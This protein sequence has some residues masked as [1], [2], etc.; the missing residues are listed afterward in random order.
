MEAGDRAGRL[1]VLE[2]PYCT[3]LFVMVRTLP[4]KASAPGAELDRLSGDHGL[5]RILDVAACRFAG[6]AC[7]TQSRAEWVLESVGVSQQQLAGTRPSRWRQLEQRRLENEGRMSVRAGRSLSEY[8]VVQIEKRQDFTANGLPASH[9]VQL[10]VGRP[11]QE[12]TNRPANGPGLYSTADASLCSGW[13][14]SL[15]ASCPP[16]M[17]SAAAAPSMA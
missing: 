1:L 9:S 6:G 3:T 12:A 14:L 2:R 7:V 10:N 13:P 8:P 15:P 17:A 4:W 11:L 16:W 5:H